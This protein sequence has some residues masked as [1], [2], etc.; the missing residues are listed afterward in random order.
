MLLFKWILCLAV[1]F[2]Y[3]FFEYTV[4]HIEIHPEVNT[5]RQFVAIRW[6]DL[7]IFSVCIMAVMVTLTGIA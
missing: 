5:V 1:L 4:H 7:V 3:M 2:G 6:K